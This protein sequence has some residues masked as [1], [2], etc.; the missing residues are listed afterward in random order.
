MRGNNSPLNWLLGW[1]KLSTTLWNPSR[2]YQN[3]RLKNNPF[4]ERFWVH[5][6]AIRFVVSG[7]ESIISSPTLN[8]PRDIVEFS[9]SAYNSGLVRV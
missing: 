7:V 1:E 5:V 2:W 4:K 8:I 9:W 6:M 3:P